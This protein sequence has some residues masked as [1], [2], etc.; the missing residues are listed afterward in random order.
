MI[1]SEIIF[2]THTHPKL[3]LNVQGMIQS[4]FLFILHFPAAATQIVN[5][6]LVYFTILY[7]SQERPESVEFRLLN[8]K[9]PSFVSKGVEFG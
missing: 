2:H 5:T 8:C 4:N 3:F 1:H 9:L 7:D 6:I